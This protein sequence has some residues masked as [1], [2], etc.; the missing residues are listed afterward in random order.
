[1]KGFGKEFSNKAKK[2]NDSL[3]KKVDYALAIHAKGNIKQAL[4]YY[5]QI[6][7]SGIEDPRV[8]S[9]L[10][11]IS[12]Q[13]SEIE[14]AIKY[15]LKS[16]AI[17]PQY[18]PG[19]SNLAVLFC[20]KGN[21]DQAEK[22][23]REA[24]KINPIVAKS[25]LNLGEI[26]SKKFELNKAEEEIRH[27]IA[28][29]P[30]MIEAYYILTK[31]LI[32][33][34]DY[35]EAEKI[36]K[37]VIN[38]SPSSAKSHFMLHQIYSDSGKLSKAKDS[39]YKTIELDPKFALAYDSLSRFPNCEKDLNFV[40]KLSHLN[41]KEIN[42]TEDKI[43]ILFAQSNI[44]HR[45]KQYEESA[46][47]LNKANKLKLTIYNS[48]ASQLIKVSKDYLIKTM[49]YKKNR[50]EKVEKNQECIFLVGMPRSG[51]TLI[52]T[53]LNANTNV[54]GMGERPLVE[55][56]LK[57]ILSSDKE[58]KGNNTL[59]KLYLSERGK[60]V[61][62]GFTSTDKYLHNYIYLGYILNSLPYAKIIHCFRNPLDN[63]LS[64]YKAN[65]GEGI[66]FA[67][68]LKDCARVYINHIE[69][70]KEYQK[71]F[72]SNIYSLNYD[73]L[74]TNP[75][76]EIK[77]LIEWLNWEWNQIY[78]SPQ[79]VN[80]NIKTASVIQVR[81]PINAKSLNGWEKYRKMLKPAIAELESNN[82]MDYIYK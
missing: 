12:L 47:F 42:S 31:I 7:R 49:K 38:K 55:M 8:Y 57:K 2:S 34:E 62:P 1:M 59:D 71:R 70:I 35:M 32:E 43:N 20:Q 82:L 11:F 64:I 21:Y 58:S 50:G 14:K 16:I 69:I 13:N 10:G 22:H 27:A 44:L 81:S 54:I 29:E 5:N 45:K 3:I 80:R 51:S 26:L 33:K 63:I 53:I 56:S 76:I 75:A 79:N 18:A 23:I 24:I 74:V 72:P 67:S 41:L 17:S 4:I 19:H 9:A 6:I 28:L 78:L 46:V 25:F 40:N 37:K 68:S 15:N 60:F 30:N 61:K 39:L 65:F 77:K 36:I 73:L 52:E 48:T 66:R